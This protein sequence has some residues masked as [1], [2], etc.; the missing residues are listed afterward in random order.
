MTITEADYDAL[1]ARVKTLEDT[2][3][4][5]TANGIDT[6]LLQRGFTFGQQL[7]R[8]D[9]S[10]IQAA[11]STLGGTPAQNPF[12]FVVPNFQTGSATDIFNAIDTGSVNGTAISGNSSP[13]SLYEIRSVYHGTKTG[14]AILQLSPVGDVQG[15]ASITAT[16]NSKSAVLTLNTDDTY[17]DGYVQV[18]PALYFNPLTA[19]PAGVVDGYEWYRSDTKRFR[20]RQN[21]SSVN[22]VTSDTTADDLTQYALLAGRSGGQ[23]LIG[24]T[25]SGNNLTL[26]SSSNATRG[27]IVLGNAG[28]TAY[29][30]V[31]DRIGIGTSSPSYPLDVTGNVRLAGSSGGVSIGTSVFSNAA[32][33]IGGTVGND[34]TNTFLM[35]TASTVLT[36]PAGGSGFG[37]YT[38]GTANIASGSGTS[39][40]AFVAQQSKTGAG[41]IATAYGMYLQNPVIATTNYALVTD[42]GNSGFGIV[43]PTAT[44]HVSGTTKLAGGDTTIRSDTATP[45]GGSTS[46]RL[47]FGTTAGFG[48]YYGSGAPTVSA[49]SGSLY[50]RT[51]NAGANLRLYSNTTGST[52][53]AAIT[54]A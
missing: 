27:K 45:A 30:D 31:N 17:T 50:I 34:G 1:Q 12:M 43:T 44:L 42:G 38:G 24:G 18:S 26:K 16:Y 53:W 49:A 23:T 52:T 8:I 7:V 28:T 39:Y 2:L 40:C 33:A 47:L 19:D 11:L 32:L 54:S 4:L 9:R 13:F 21:G 6:L 15:R 35:Y 3:N 37:L 10:G 25:A 20:V 51:D 29:D 5:Y 41:T 36:I 48:I 22:L 46:A 14:K